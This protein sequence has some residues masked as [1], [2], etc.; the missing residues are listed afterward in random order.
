MDAEKVIN[1]PGEN[2]AVKQWQLLDD[3][4]IISSVMGNEKEDEVEDDST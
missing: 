1:Y 3:E 4:Q 2:E